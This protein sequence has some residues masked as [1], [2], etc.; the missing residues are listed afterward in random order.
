M[1]GIM[2]RRVSLR[3]LCGIARDDRE[4]SSFV[5]CA[6]AAVFLR[7]GSW[8]LACGLLVGTPEQAVGGTYEYTKIA[9]TSLP[10]NDPNAL[11]SPTINNSGKVLF[12]GWATH[13]TLPAGPGYYV[14][15][16]VATG[17]FAIMD[18]T[19]FACCTSGGQSI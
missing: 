3:F 12:F 10:L 16:G 18:N 4:S 15:D 1:G 2:K 8:L 9:E 19:T 7:G 5:P 6:G 17:P 11:Q 13:D 14:G